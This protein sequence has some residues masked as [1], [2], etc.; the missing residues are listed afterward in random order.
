MLLCTISADIDGIGRINTE[1]ISD[2]VRMELLVSNIENT[3]LLRDADGEFL[4]IR[5]WEGLRFNKLSQ[6]VRINFSRISQVIYYDDDDDDDGEDEGEDPYTIGPGGSVDLKWVPQSV[7]DLAIFW[8]DLEGTVE[9]CFLPG[10][11][12]LFSIQSNHFRGTF[13][14]ESLPRELRSVVISANRLSGTL[15]MDKLP[16]TLKCFDAERNQFHGALDLTDL[17]LSINIIRLEFN[18]FSGTIDL[19]KLPPK[20]CFLRTTNTKIKQERL[21]VRVPE[22]GLRKFHLGEHMFTSAFDTYGN[23]ITDDLH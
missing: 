9:T 3:R 12:E 10:H 1:S 19:S 11:L 14:I 8:M 18:D 6:I 21:V 2:Q 15:R 5:S 13:C 17:P 7:T 20:I 23:E 4:D 16:P 22:Q